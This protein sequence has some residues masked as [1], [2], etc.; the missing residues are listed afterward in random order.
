MPA[1]CQDR[2]LS[3]EQME[4]FHREGFLIVENVLSD[5]DLQPVIDE[6]DREI[7]AR[8]RKLLA[9]KKLTQLYDEFPFET[10]LGHIS[11]ETNEIAGAIWNGSLS[12]PAFFNLICH[13]KLL[14]I[15]EQFCGAKSGAVENDRLS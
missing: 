13:R 1:T 14:D 4:R 12:G 11:K 9:E 10:R 5:A 8:A 7:D 15:A 2:R 6:I 3:S